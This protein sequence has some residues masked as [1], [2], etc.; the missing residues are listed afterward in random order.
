MPE[1]VS[2][3]VEPRYTPDTHPRLCRAIKALVVVLVTVRHPIK[4]LRPLAIILGQRLR[5]VSFRDSRHGGRAIK[6]LWDH[7]GHDVANTLIR[8]VTFCT[9]INQ[10]GLSGQTALLIYAADLTEPSRGL[11]VSEINLAIARYAR[12]IAAARQDTTERTR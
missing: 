4:T 7:C 9:A 8:E 5:G 10:I 3:P 12:Q 6:R 1:T 11:G 2:Q